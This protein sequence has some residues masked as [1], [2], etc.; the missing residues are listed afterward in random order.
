M[1][2]TPTSTDA[3]PHAL[4]P[5]RTVISPSR[6]GKLAGRRAVI[7]AFNKP[8]ADH[9][10]RLLSELS[11]GSVKQWP[12]SRE[13]QA[14]WDA[15][16]NTRN[17][18]IMD[19]VAGSGKSHAIFGAVRQL[20]DLGCG[21]EVRTYHALGLDAVKA[22]TG[23]RIDVVKDAYVR[24][25]VEAA[26]DG[27][28]SPASVRAL[29]SADKGKAIRTAMK[30]LGIC[31]NA[32]IDVRVDDGHRALIGYA[33]EKGMDTESADWHFGVYL[34]S[35]V[36][37][38]QIQSAIHAAGRGSR[39]TLKVTYNDMCW[40]PVQMEGWKLPVFDYVF[41]DELQDTNPAQQALAL[42]V[43]GDRG[44][45]IG[46]GD[47][48]QA[49]YA[50]RG[51]ATGAM[52][53]VAGALENVT[54]LELTVSRRCPHS[55]VRLARA[56]VPQIKALPEAVH[57]TVRATDLDS[58]LDEVRGV[59]SRY[60]MEDAGKTR[61]VMV[62]CRVNAD[63]IPFAYG[64]IRLGVPASVLGREI[65]DG[66]I[67]IAERLHCDNA[68]DDDCG[69]FVHSLDLWYDSEAKKAGK[70]TDDD[71]KRER[72]EKLYDVYSCLHAVAGTVS[73]KDSDAAGG[74]KQAVLAR[75]DSLFSDDTGK[76]VVCGTIHRT[77]GLE[78]RTVYVL[79]PDILGVVGNGGK[80]RKRTD[81]EK[82][83]ELNLAYIAVTRWMEE[84]V[85]VEENGVR[86]PEVFRGMMAE[87]WMSE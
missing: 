66:L 37:H 11:S 76:R 55:A 20:V 13:Q 84:G 56:I 71:E 47:S 42:G 86:V 2:Y 22:N 41:V 77:K 72:L 53:R 69:E 85:F 16:L 70:L 40:L 7:V 64:L 74:F 21:A 31:K 54:R 52:E 29:S 61:Q 26:C 80:G 60:G 83:Q 35:V 82:Q 6:R 73:G 5:S 14:F 19:S 32:L 46:V 65:G 10:Q 15:V 17:H 28:E 79:R 51:A 87:T 62:I 27:R 24:G 57:G 78:A 12:G 38:E 49:I 67:G 44:R 43:I 39:A 1:P 34:A 48:H 36:L 3:S 63:L 50:F 45:L 68:C 8:I 25:M 18:I 23:G 81:E 30:I 9:G 59:V 4:S 75:L 33:R 58:A